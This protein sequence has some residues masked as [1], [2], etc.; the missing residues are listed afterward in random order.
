MNFLLLIM[1]YFLVISVY[2]L[3]TYYN[4]ISVVKEKRD[5]L[6]V[7]ILYLVI[8]LILYKFNFIV[9]IIIFSVIINYKYGLLL[10]NIK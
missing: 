6:I 7:L 1:C 8:S 4:K 10:Y 5:T 9:L 3:I 2:T